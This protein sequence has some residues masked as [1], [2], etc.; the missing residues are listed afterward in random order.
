LFI[1]SQSEYGWGWVEFLSLALLIPK[2]YPV[3]NILAD[4]FFVVEV[5]ENRGVDL[6]ESE[7]MIGLLNFFSGTRLVNVLVQNGFDADA[8]SLDADVIGG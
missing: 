2:F 1:F 7:R 8:G 6:F 4:R 3:S 5:V